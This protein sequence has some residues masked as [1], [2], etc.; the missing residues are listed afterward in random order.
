MRRPFANVPSDARPYAVRMR[1]GVRLATDVY[2]PTGRGP[3]PVL[4]SRLPYDKAGDECFMPAI[5]RWFNERGYAVVVQDVRGKIRSGGDLEPFRAEVTDGYDTIEWITEQDWS[6]GAVGMFGDSYFGWTQWA[7]AASQHQ[8][9][10]AIAP[11]VISADIGDVVTRGGQFRLE[12]MG[13][14]A[15]ETWVDEY[16]YGYEDTVDWSARPL[17]EVVP[18]ALSGRRS[19]FLDRL[20]QEG[21]PESGRLS[22][23]GDVPALHLGGW[24]DI[25]RDGQLDTWRR[26]AAAGNAP[27]FLVMD[28]VDHGWTRLRT[29]GEPYVDPSADSAA[30]SVLEDYLGP[31]VPFFDH[32]LAGS[33][34]Y[35]AP[36]VRWMLTHAGWQADAEWPP[37][38]SVPI[39]WHLTGHRRGLLSPTPE[40]REQV[41]EW[42]QEPD[43]LVPSLAH[44][45]HP[46]VEP[47][48]DSALDDRGDVL[49]FH[50]DPLPYSLDLAGPVSLTASCDSSS[51][52]ARIMVSLCDLT[53]DGSALRIV[54]GVAAVESD[55]PLTVRLGDTGYRVRAGHRLR[56]QVSASE[57]PRYLPDTGTGD[58]SWTAT[59][60]LATHHRVVIGGERGARLQCFAI[61]ARG[62]D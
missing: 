40:E 57:F 42:T 52:G 38:R 46:L 26:A 37:T 21:V 58:D 48:D 49:I 6:T 18:K 62:D 19:E 3:W 41:V 5:A 47:A 23:R 1:D 35:D 20:A 29:P 45:Y 9:L 54:D 50:S 44:A 61:P 11:R 31:L 24:W 14:W 55:V 15:L 56:L 60:F 13:L 7:A 12:M 43:D 51:P 25:V 53:P 10:R 4:L 22:V 36:P 16:L 32:Y 30:M 59:E 39:E 17:S 28:A 33:G 27:Q 34:A 2:L 8:A